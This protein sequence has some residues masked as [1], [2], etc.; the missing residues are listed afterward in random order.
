MCVVLA[1]STT[2]SLPSLTITLAGENNSEF[3]LIIQP[4]HYLRVAQ[5]SQAL[6]YGS[7]CRV[8]A[9]TAQCGTVLGVTVMTAYT[10]LFD[11]ANSRIGFARSTC[12]NASGFSSVPAIATRTSTTSSCVVD[13][14]L[15][16][17]TTSSS[18]VSGGIIAGAVIGG[19]IGAGILLSALIWHYAS[20]RDPV[21]QTVIALGTV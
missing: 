9:I 4:W 2:S 5:I 17:T 10:V 8:F 14:Q 3:D 11:R 16:A 21:R 20:K 15:C 1:H 12:S 19:V 6:P 7:D 13:P 18:S